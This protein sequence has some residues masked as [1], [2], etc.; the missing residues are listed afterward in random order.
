ME[1]SSSSYEDLIYQ[2]IKE[3][4]EKGIPLKDIYW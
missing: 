3:A 1:S 4:G 2:K